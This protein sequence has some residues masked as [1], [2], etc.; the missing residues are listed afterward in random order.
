MPLALDRVR[1]GYNDISAD[2]ASA[3]AFLLREGP[4]TLE[5]LELQGNRIGDAGAVILSQGLAGDKISGDDGARGSQHEAGMNKRARG[6]NSMGLR[7]MNLAGNGI[8]CVGGCALAKSLRGRSNGGGGGKS[9]GRKM[10]VLEEL[11]LA[12]N[13]VRFAVEILFVVASRRGNFSLSC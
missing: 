9:S 13:A 7:R 1:L 6:G 8:G 3:L 2:G 12:G 5:S 10:L 4:G 11:E